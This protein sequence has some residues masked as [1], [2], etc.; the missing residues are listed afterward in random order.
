MILELLHG[1]VPPHPGLGLLPQNR[2]SR[3]AE[4]RPLDDCVVR[5]EARPGLRGSAEV[6]DEVLSGD[7]DEGLA[8]PLAFIFAEVVV[9]QIV[10]D[11]HAFEKPADGVRLA[12]VDRTVGLTLPRPATGQHP[13]APRVA[14]AAV[15]TDGIGEGQ[16][17]RHC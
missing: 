10:A 1:G 17:L 6:V 8:D 12:A 5:M 13:P 2:Q 9:E 14:V 11:G 3:H 15:L 7:A 4:R 16:V